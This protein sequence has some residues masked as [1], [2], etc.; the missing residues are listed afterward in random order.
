MP[1]DGVNFA[2]AYERSDQEESDSTG[3]NFPKNC[4]NSK[5]FTPIGRFPRRH[6]Q[7]RMM[8]VSAARRGH[9]WE[10]C[11]IHALIQ[12]LLDAYLCATLLAGV[13]MPFEGKRVEI[14]LTQKPQL[15]GNVPFVFWVEEREMHRKRVKEAKL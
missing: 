8:R 2:N 1:E 5:W 9:Q 10:R 12:V 7:T 14:G 13:G 4:S 11:D 3:A 6:V 15:S